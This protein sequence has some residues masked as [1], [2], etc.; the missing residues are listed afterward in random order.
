MHSIGYNNSMLEQVPVV[1]LV[2]HPSSA[3]INDSVE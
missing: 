3:S 1:L 2:F